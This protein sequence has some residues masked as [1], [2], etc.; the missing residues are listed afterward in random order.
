M[1]P[2]VF[3]EK[4]RQCALIR[5]AFFPA[6][7]GPNGLIQTQQLCIAA[8][9]GSQNHTHQKRFNILEVVCTRARTRLMEFQLSQF[10]PESTM[11]HKFLNVSQTA[12]WRYQF[13]TVFEREIAHPLGVFTHT[14]KLLIFNGITRICGNQLH[15][16]G[17]KY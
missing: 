12:P 9:F 2:I 15:N 4:P 10:L 3:A 7:H 14:R 16:L 8:S 1:V 13:V 17:L 5:H 6:K 11:F